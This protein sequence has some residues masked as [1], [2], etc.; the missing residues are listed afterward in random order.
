V[1]VPLGTPPSKPLLQLGDAKPAFALV[2]GGCCLANAA[3]GA[4][5]REI[6]AVQEILGDK[7]P[8]QADTR[9]VRSLP[10]W[11]YPQIPQP[12]YC[13]HAFWRKQKA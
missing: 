8:L 6:A 5:G 4:A 7:I 13:R 11:K 12:A 10:R 9:S 3:E 1:N 2:L